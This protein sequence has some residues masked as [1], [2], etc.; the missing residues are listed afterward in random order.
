MS[1]IATAT[2]P[3]TPQQDERQ[4]GVYPAD[5]PA[6]VHPEEAGDEHER[7][8]HRRDDGQPVHRPKRF[9]PATGNTLAT[10]APVQTV[11]IVR[12]TQL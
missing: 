11:Q 8:E 4:R 6:E 9:S 5:H 12:E 2:Q 7:Q 10:S 3:P 1:V